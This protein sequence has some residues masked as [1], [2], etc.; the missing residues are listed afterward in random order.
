MDGTRTGQLTGDLGTETVEGSARPLQGV[1]D[2]EGSDG[3]ALGMLSVGD[4]VT[5]DLTR[6]G[7]RL[8]GDAGRRL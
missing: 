2:I 6:Q 8:L 5:N 3:L 4:R 1:D 7:R